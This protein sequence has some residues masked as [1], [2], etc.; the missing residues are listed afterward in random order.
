MEGA[1]Q[2]ERNEGSGPLVYQLSGKAMLGS[3]AL[4]DKS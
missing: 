4:M 2:Y 1:L 3:Y